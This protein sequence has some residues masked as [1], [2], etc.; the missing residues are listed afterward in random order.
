MNLSKK[1]SPDPVFEMILQ[2]SSDM[3]A[4]VEA[5]KSDFVLPED[6]H[7][8]HQ[9]GQLAVDVGQTETEVVIV[10]TMAGAVTEK[11][12]VYLHNDLFTIRGE[13]ACPRI[14][15]GAVEYFHHECFWGKFS[16]TIVLPVDVKADLAKAEYKNGILTVRVPKQKMDTKIPVVIVDD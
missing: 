16:R 7:E 4:S 1:S 8:E 5:K 10:S 15:D 9:E 14:G 13:R 3:P 2:S 6:W 12:E 11:I